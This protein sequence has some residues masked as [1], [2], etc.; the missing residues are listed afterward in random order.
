MRG[1]TI[2][3]SFEPIFIKKY[4]SSDFPDSPVIKTLFSNEGAWVQ[5]VV[6]ELKYHTP[7]RQK[8]KH[9]AKAIL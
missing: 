5:S 9:K 1:A 6:Q 8:T 4:L 3:L 7:R 2:A